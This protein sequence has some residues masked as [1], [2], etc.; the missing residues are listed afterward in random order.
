MQQRG[1]K[2]IGEWTIE[3]NDIILRR[4]QHARFSSTEFLQLTNGIFCLILFNARMMRSKEDFLSFRDEDEE[5]R[6]KKRNF[7][8]QWDTRKKATTTMNDGKVF[9]ESNARAEK[10]INI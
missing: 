5:I 10:K 3:R 2:E 6:R 4:L 7:R 9:E 8:F 1:K